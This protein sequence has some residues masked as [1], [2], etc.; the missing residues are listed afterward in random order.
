MADATVTGRVTAE[1]PMRLLRS[2]AY[3]SLA[4]A[5]AQVVFGA[6][7]RIT[8]SGLGC[9][10]HWPTCQGYLL[11]PLERPDLIVEVTHRY[12]A[13][14]V[15]VA[16]I[17]LLAAAFLRRKE[18]GVGGPGGVLRAAGLAA[19]LVVTAAVFGAITVKMLLNP[20]VIVTH[21]AI[22]M[23]LLAVLSTAVLRAGGWGFDGTVVASPKTYRAA[24]AAAVLAFVV[25]VMGALT[26]NVAGANVSCGGFPWCRWVALTG[27]PLDIQI[28]HR[29]IAFLLLF[30]VFG[31]VTALRK[32]DESRIVGRGAAFALAAI[33]LQIVVAAVL[34]ER[35]L[36]PV[37]RSLHQAA[38]TLVWLSVFTFAALAK[39]AA[40]E[41]TARSARAA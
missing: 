12:I 17:S 35:G 10:D 3:V 9:G 18:R 4:L 14:A 30:H 13:V 40:S 5:F 20:Y 15:T 2:V 16:I 11:P 34:V 29:V 38:G 26:A 37:W 24:R 25:V 22:A 33:V 31:L 28:T 41:A 39:Y 23:T 36:P 19:G 7:V 27:G 21:L 1:G 8:G 6:I 32:R